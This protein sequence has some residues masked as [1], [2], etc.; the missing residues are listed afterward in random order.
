MKRDKRA[1]TL[2]ELLVVISIIALLVSILLP[3]L[4]KAREAAK[5][6]IDGANMHQVGLAMQ[7]YG[8][9]NKQRTV[10]GN[11]P[12]GNN[13]YANNIKKPPGSPFEPVLVGLLLEGEYL[14]E[15]SSNDHPFFDPGVS[16]T[17]GMAVFDYRHESRAR[18]Y[19]HNW[20]RGYTGIQYEYRDTLDGTGG[21]IGG[22]AIKFNDGPNLDKLS[23]HAYYSCLIGAGPSEAVKIH[24]FK[25]N[26]LFGDASV[27][28]IRG[29][30]GLG[31]KFFDYVAYNWEQYGSLDDSAYYRMIDDMFGVARWQIPNDGTSFGAQSGSD[32]DPRLQDWVLQGYYE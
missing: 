22:V 16:P 8:S 17:M 4:N 31:L 30:T 11:N 28:S 26:L 15:P 3:A 5:F 23:K 14:P 12:S 6:T 10:S 29:E 9:D 25:I 32:D 27:Q 18:D 20:G 21:N 24:N 7:N 1:F 13:I 2:V 19:Y